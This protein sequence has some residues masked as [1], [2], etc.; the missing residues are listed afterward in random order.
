MLWNKH[1]LH[2]NNYNKKNGVEAENKWCSM[3]GSE[4]TKECYKVWL[5]FDM[6][7]P[8]MFVLINLKKSIMNALEQG[9]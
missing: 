7:W 3:V 9:S 5:S 2:Q 8:G 1:L 4:Y 6:K